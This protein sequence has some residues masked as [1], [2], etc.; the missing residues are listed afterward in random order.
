MEAC[1]AR[2]HCSRGICTFMVLVPDVLLVSITV[3]SMFACLHS[4]KYQFCMFACLLRVILANPLVAKVFA[5]GLH[6]KP[7]VVVLVLL[8]TCKQHTEHGLGGL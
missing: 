6:S 2:F 7:T 3:P 1:F 8:Q 5:V 4:V